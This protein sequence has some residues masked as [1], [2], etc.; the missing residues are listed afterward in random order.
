MTITVLLAD[1][2]PVVRKGIASLLAEDPQI[3]LVGEAKDGPEAVKLI[4]E[5]KPQVALVDIAMSSMN[6]IQVASAVSK[7][8]AP[9]RIIMLSMYSDEAYVTR[10]LRAGARGYLVKDAAEPDILQAIHKV[11]QGGLFFSSV[12]SD[13]LLTGYV[14]RL[15]E[16]ESKDSYDLLT[17]R[18]KEILRLLA[19]AKSNKEVAAELNLSP[20]TVET[21][22]N[23]LMQKLDLHSAAEIVLYAV[24]KRIIEH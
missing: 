2:H 7:Q 10:S 9:T 11:A 18:E 1:D 22:R 5:R 16:E 12:I 24:R 4:L 21:H 8:G 19:M 13:S 20:S 14:R 15:R 17:D 23:N 6:G 3:E